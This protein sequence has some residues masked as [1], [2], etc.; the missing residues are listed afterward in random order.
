MAENYSGKQYT[1]TLGTKDQ[2]SQAIGTATVA[3][4]AS[5]VFRVQSPV[6]DIN[7]DGGF[8]TADISRAGRM[9]MTAEDRFQH[10]GS[11]SWTWDFDY[12]V[13][14][15]AVA[16]T[17]LKAIGNGQTT[18]TSMI[19]NEAN[20]APSD[21]YTHGKGG[22]TDVTCNIIINNPDADEDRVMHS[23]VLQNLGLSMDVGVDAGRLHM[24]GQFMTGYKPV[25]GTDST[26]PATTNVDWTNGIFDLTTMEIGGHAVTLKSFNLN[27]ENPASRMGFQGTSGET[28]GYSRGGDANVTGSAVI[29]VDATSVTFLDD[30]IANTNT[31]I[32][33]ESGSSWSIALA[34]AK[35][36]GHSN[37]WADDGA[38]VEIPFVGTTGANGGSDLCT[39]KIT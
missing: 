13:D 6:N 3:N 19:F 16:Q 15:E 35:I 12:L 24:T 38:F 11:G 17:L 18:T 5:H 8:Q 28:D 9:M 31:A 27:L 34:A 25:I 26:S 37:D 2:S 29:K 4:V 39:I 14:N 30:W 1:V 33:M 7:F 22:S 23:A 10:Y 21:L 32:T 20:L 36:T